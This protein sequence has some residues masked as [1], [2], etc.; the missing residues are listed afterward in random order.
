MLGMWCD[1]QLLTFMRNLVAFY[2][3]FR[4][5]H[6]TAGMVFVLAVSQL[7][8]KVYNFFVVQQIEV[9]NY[10]IG[11]VGV[12]RTDDCFLIVGN[13]SNLNKTKPFSDSLLI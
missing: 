12:T 4:L 11:D 13:S 10:N 9:F 7:R 8:K 2:L 5:C 6:Y 3:S 1:I